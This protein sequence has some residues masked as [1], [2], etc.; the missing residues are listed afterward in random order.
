MGGN[1]PYCHVEKGQ[2]EEVK[3]FLPAP[4]PETDDANAGG[5]VGVWSDTKRMLI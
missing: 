5:V 3:L 4:L 2:M 1:L